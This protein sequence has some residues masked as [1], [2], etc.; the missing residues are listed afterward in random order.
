MTP[1]LEKDYGALVN[2]KNE[3]ELDLEVNAKLPYD[4]FTVFFL[5]VCF[6]YYI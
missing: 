3:L 6:D 5:C 2:L 4:Q 1:F